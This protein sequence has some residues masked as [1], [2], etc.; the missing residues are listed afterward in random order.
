MNPVGRAVL[1]V[2]TTAFFA[3]CGGG[4]DGG[5]DR[6][7]ELYKQRVA[8]DLLNEV[9]APQS[10]ID[11]AAR[12]LDVTC[13]PT[14]AP[15]YECTTQTSTPPNAACTVRANGDQTRIED[16]RCGVTGE[17]PV[18]TAEY[19]DCSTVAPVVE[20]ADPE[21][22]LNENQRELGPATA[23]RKELRNIDLTAMRVAGTSERL[24]VEWE[25]AGPI[26]TE[27]RHSF[28]LWVYPV[29]EQSWRISL[30]VTFENGK[31]PDVSASAMG[32]I[33][34]R[35][36]TR[37]RWTSIVIDS[38]D[39][40]PDSRSVLGEPF[41]FSSQ[42]TWVGRTDPDQAYGDSLPNGSERPTYAG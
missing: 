22:D 40:H 35:A 21:G 34:G 20:V 12:E 13:K 41:T 31:A 19:V 23:R 10:R 7:E 2:I 5:A 14:R 27:P 18:T 39:L 17:A 37:G 25:T 29:G 6:V 30:A 32:S 8:A 9:D 11:E 28:N 15:D 42:N 3:A 1:V 33:S 26:P 24:C 36:G 4:N 16:V 38:D